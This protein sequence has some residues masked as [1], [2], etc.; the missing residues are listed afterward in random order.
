MAS[1]CG[2]RGAGAAFSTTGFGIGAGD[3]AFSTTGFGGAGAA[4]S[5]TG[6]GGG[7]VS[8]FSTTGAGG[9]G[10]GFST[11]GTNLS[12]DGAAPVS[13]WADFTPPGSLLSGFVAG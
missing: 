5:T 12:T 13:T 4:F 10:T 2:F 6:F 7:A 8:A 3:G 1:G 9:G 11:G